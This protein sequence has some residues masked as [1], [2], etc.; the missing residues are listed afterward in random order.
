MT[1]LYPF[2]TVSI[3]AYNAEKHIVETINSILKQKTNFLFN[4]LI[5]DD[6]STDST[7]KICEDF[8]LNNDNIKLIRHQSNIGMMRNQ[9]FVITEPK[10]KYIAYLDS[11]DFFVDEN[12]LQNQVDFLDLNPTVSCVFSNVENFH[13]KLQHIKKV[14]NKET[15]PPTIF[16]LHTY[17]QNGISI[18]NSA[19]VFKQEFSKDIPESFTDYFQY[20]WL[21]HIHHGLNGFFG[22]NDFVGTRYRIHDNNATNLKNAEKRF[23]DAIN[24]VYSVKKYLPNEYHTYF[25]HPN[26]ELNSLAFFYLYDGRYTK[27]IFWYFKWLRV[28]PI[29]K[30]IFRDE[31]YK[32]RQSLF[33]RNP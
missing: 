32:F 22:Y 7:N 21:L 10:T 18:T 31:F 30:I 16:D 11:D 6:F 12:Y 8:A 19:M 27:Y 1:K 3:P 28:T 26:F 5:A 4:I 29:K 2:L 23:L 33:K 17:F 13:D 25:K 20:D 9:H 14:Y 24:L 15:R